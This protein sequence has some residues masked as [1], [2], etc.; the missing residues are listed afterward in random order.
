MISCYLQGSSVCRGFVVDVRVKNL[1]LVQVF[2]NLWL[3][4][5]Q[6]ISYI[7]K[8]TIHKV[9]LSFLHFVVEMCSHMAL[10]V[11]VSSVYLNPKLLPNK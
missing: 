11:Q 9:K 5:V 1:Q 3:K 7:V 8:Y 10:S 6:N 2:K 4:H